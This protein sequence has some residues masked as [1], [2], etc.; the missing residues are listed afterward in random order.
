MQLQA[1]AALWMAELL[2]R[3]CI[4]PAWPVLP[5]MACVANDGSVV[6]SLLYFGTQALKQLSIRFCTLHFPNSLL[7][8]GR[9]GDSR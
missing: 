1:T 2:I 5:T 8:F 4:S 6:D 3:F 7:N 9:S